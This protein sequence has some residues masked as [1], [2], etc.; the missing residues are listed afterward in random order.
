M[1][2]GAGGAYACEHS[3]A[4]HAVPC[5]RQARRAGVWRLCRHS[6]VPGAWLERVNSA[7][8]ITWTGSYFACNLR[9]VDF[10]RLRG[11]AMSNLVMTPYYAVADLSV[12]SH[13]HKMP[14][15]DSWKR[16]QTGEKG[17]EN[18]KRG[19]GESMWGAGISSAD[20]FVS[21]FGTQ[22]PQMYHLNTA[23][24][25]TQMYK[26]FIHTQ[27]GA[28]EYAFNLWRLTLHLDPSKVKVNAVAVTAGTKCV[29]TEQKFSDIYK[30]A[31]GHQKFAAYGNYA[32]WR[33]AVGVGVGKCLSKYIDNITLTGFPWYPAFAAFPGPVAPPMPNVPWP[34]IA[35]PSSGVS[36]I[37]NPS[38]LK[39]AMVGEFEKGDCYQS[40]NDEFYKT[41]YEAIANA[42]ALA[43][44]VWLST[45]MIS[46]VQGTGNVPSFAPPY[47]PVG[48]VVN[49][50][51]LPSP[52]GQFA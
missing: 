22:D 49:G 36:E 26:D 38:A 16:P 17:E 37:L 35:C 51:V 15:E 19:V 45:Q 44:T 39:K 27:L 30:T 28:I 24:T 46:L 25:N 23:L 4:P 42:S 40:S 21:Y 18:Y 3:A 12:A 43:F 29:V 9:R 2:K 34:L 1:G 10:L 13:Q 11:V 6:R 8:E 52:G 33:D 5:F 47:V 7:N 31:P 20:G 32:Q 50:T 41:C 14:P 48:P